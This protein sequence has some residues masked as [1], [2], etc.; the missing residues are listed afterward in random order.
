[1]CRACACLDLGLRLPCH[2]AEVLDHLPVGDRLACA[3]LAA[4]DDG[5]VL[6]RPQPAV[7]LLH[8]PVAMRPEL[9]VAPGIRA[10]LLVGPDPLLAVDGQLHERVHRDE[11]GADTAVHDRR[12]LAWVLALR[13]A[14][15][16]HEVVEHRSRVQLLQLVHLRNAPLVDRSRQQFRCIDGPLLAAAIE[17][18]HPD[19]AR[20]AAELLHD[21]LN[22]RVLR[23]GRPARSALDPAHGR[24][25]RCGVG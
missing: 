6:H 11:C 9:L 8:R 2:L 1:M 13:L 10:R 25:H 17:A 5:L 23:V 20:G 22:E 21:G 4:D 15:Q 7:S 24:R 14:E 12:A 19:N 16:H 3:G 18:G